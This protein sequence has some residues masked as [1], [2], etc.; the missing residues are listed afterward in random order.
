MTA[1]PPNPGIPVVDIREV[2][3][4]ST[5]PEVTFDQ[6]AS[7]RIAYLVLGI[8]AGVYGLAFTLTGFATFL[9]NDATYDKAIEVLKFMVSSIL[10]LVTLAVG[11]YLGERRSSED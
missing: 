6:I 5:P 7:L 2:E 10:P 9:L 11:Y 1:S 3:E 8:F 4:W